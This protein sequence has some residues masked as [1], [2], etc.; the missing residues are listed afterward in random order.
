MKVN[1]GSQNCFPAFASWFWSCWPMVPSTWIAWESSSFLPKPCSSKFLCL[2]PMV[3]KYV[4]M[5]ECWHHLSL[6]MGLNQG[7][8][9]IITIRTY[10]KIIQI[11]PVIRG[12]QTGSP[13]GNPQ[14]SAFCSLILKVL[15]L[16]SFPKMVMALWYFLIIKVMDTLISKV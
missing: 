2:L 1:W 14:S 6:K 11:V 5:S 9:L 13:Q 4:E 16:F 8:K 10:N 3:V 12:K 7:A 15:F